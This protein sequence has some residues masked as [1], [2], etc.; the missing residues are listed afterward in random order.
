M[1]FGLMSSRSFPPF[2]FSRRQQASCQS[3]CLGVLRRRTL[4]VKYPR[5]ARYDLHLIAQNPN[6][7]AAALQFTQDVVIAAEWLR[8][9]PTLFA[10]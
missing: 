7:V 2:D 8:M 3:Q 6:F 9:I 4:L 1:L 5:L 10:S